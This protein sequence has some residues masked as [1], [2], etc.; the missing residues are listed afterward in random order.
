MSTT[1]ATVNPTFGGTPSPWQPFTIVGAATV[2]AA[3]SDASD[4]SYIQSGSSLAT[5]KQQLMYVVF[6][7]LNLPAGAVIEY[8]QPVIRERHAAGSGWMTVTEITARNNSGTH[9]TAWSQA[10]IGANPADNAFRNTNGPI[11]TKAADGTEWSDCDDSTFTAVLAWGP[12]WYETYYSTIAI[13]PALS[14][15]SLNV[16]YRLPGG[17]VVNEPGG[18]ITDPRPPVGWETGNTQEAYRVVVVAVGTTDSSGRTA[19]SSSFDPGAVLHPAFDTG[20]VYSATTASVVTSHLPP[21]IS[22]YFYV[23]TWQPSVGSVEMPTPWTRTGP[24]AVTASVVKAPT[25]LLTEDATSYTVQVAVARVAPVGAEVAPTFYGLQRWVGARSTWEDV[26]GATR[27]S[28]PGGWAYF[29]GTASAGDTVLY[30]ARGVYVLPSGV[31][32]PSTWVQATLVVTNRSEWWL[33]DPTDYTLNRR[34]EVARYS[35]SIP[36][37]QEV[38]YGAGARGATVTHQGVRLG[39][40]KVDIRTLSRTARLDLRALFDAGRSLFLVTV[41]GDAYRVQLADQ[42]EVSVIRAEPDTLETTPIRDARI[43]SCSFIEVER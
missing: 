15:V 23:R 1:I 8:V 35:E 24:F 10:Q 38:A 6:S 16:A 5:V 25:L 20:K 26:Q 14:K 41:F 9:K 7:D 43:Y 13:P 32:V 4:G 12:N 27:L 40:H 21:G 29:D 11:F 33:R 22:Y 30:R 18:P 42:T 39:V 28:G 31:E 19:G 34:I 2:H 37:P 17:T 3:L 36:K